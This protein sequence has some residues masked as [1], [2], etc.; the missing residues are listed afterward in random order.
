MS[1]SPR[2]IKAQWLSPGQA[3]DGGASRC[4][5][6]PPD[7]PLAAARREAEALLAT[8]WQQAEALVAAAR[9]EADAAAAAVRSVG[10]AEATALVAAARAEADE[11]RQAAREAAAAEATAIREQARSEGYAAGL[12]DGRA[13]AAAELAARLHELEPQAVALAL[14][15]ARRLLRRELTADPAAVLAM[16]RAGLAKLRGERPRLRVHPAVLDGLAERRGELAGA[17]P[18]AG[19]EWVPD[20]DLAPGDFVLMGAEGLVDGRLERQL[21]EVA[22]AL[23]VEPDDDP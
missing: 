12:A 16:V 5:P 11:V 10:Q 18:G 3:P 7:D 9:Q 6:P 15:V 19:L 4:A 8:A 13:A 20:P 21:R 14:A 1:S 17:L 22:A 2:L 23:G